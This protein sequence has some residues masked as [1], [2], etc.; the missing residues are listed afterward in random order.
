MNTEIIAECM[1][2]SFANTPFPAVVQKLAG[3]GITSYNADL[4]ALRKTY[5]NGGVES[6]DERMPLTEAPAIAANFDRDAVQATVK[7][8]QQQKIGY[9]EFLRQIMLAGCARYSVFFGGHKAMYFGRD[10][11]FYT[12]PFPAK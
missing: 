5:Y 6:T 10:G 2:A 4:I 12:E 1:K 9:A 7:A 8:I 11:E 3:A